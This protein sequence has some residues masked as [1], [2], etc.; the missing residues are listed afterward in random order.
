MITGLVIGFAAASALVLLAL[1]VRRVCRS[2]MSVMREP[3]EIVPTL[4][5]RG[6]RRFVVIRDEDVSHVSGTGLVC[7]GVEF[8]DKHAAIHWLGK[9]PLTTPHQD[10][11]VSIKAIHGHENKTRLVYLDEA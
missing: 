4:A 8:S 6:F 11:V 9:W 10:G 5:R 7:E 1:G 3:E 2:Y